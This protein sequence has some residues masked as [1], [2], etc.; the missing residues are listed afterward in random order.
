MNTVAMTPPS[1]AKAFARASEL[2]GTVGLR[3]VQVVRAYFNRRD[4]RTLAGF[5]DRMLADIGLSRGDVRDA[6]AEP[7]WRDPTTILVDRARERR[8]ARRPCP[9]QASVRSVGAP[10]LIPDLELG[11]RGGKLTQLSH[12]RH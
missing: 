3:V 2:A 6:I 1:A 5:D 7:L 9:G 11:L 12:R 10:S 4:I 8:L